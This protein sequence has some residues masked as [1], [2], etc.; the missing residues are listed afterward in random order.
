MAAGTLNLTIEQGAKFSRLLTWQ[1]SNGGLIDVSDYE[2]RM[3]IRAT[4]D[5]DTVLFKLL[6]TG[7]TSADGTI[8]L[9]AT[10]GTIL[11]EIGADLT[12]TITTWSSGVYDLE[13]YIAADV[14]DVT[15]LIQGSITVSPEVTRS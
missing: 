3:E 8:T 6:S 9:G 14:T 15:R 10:A 1:D 13:L 5:S 12:E 7:G 4:T 11:L 2:A